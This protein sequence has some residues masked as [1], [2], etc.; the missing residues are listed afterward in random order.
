MILLECNLETS[1][2]HVVV[3]TGIASFHVNLCKVHG[4]VA[5][6]IETAVEFALAISVAVVVDILIVEGNLYILAEIEVEGS[7][8]KFG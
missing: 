5:S 7:A 6:C 2:E 4:L 8:I 1:E 3:D